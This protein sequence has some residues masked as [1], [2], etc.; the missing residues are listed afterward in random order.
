MPV[1]LVVGCFAPGDPGAVGSLAALQGALPGWDVLVAARADGSPPAGRA[2]RGLRR[3]DALVVTGPVFGPGVRPARRRAALARLGLAAAFEVR[4]RPRAMIGVSVP[5]LDHPASR[6]FARALVGRAGLLIL[7]DAHSAR[8][9]AEAGAP[10]P[11]R[12]GADPAWVALGQPM[13][14]AAASPARI[15]AVL[16]GAAGRLAHPLEPALATLAGEGMSLRL[17]PWGRP[18]RRRAD[19]LARRLRRAGPV[20]I[21][22]PPADLRAAR[23]VLAGSRGVL[24]PGYHAAL[25]A[26][27][28]GVSFAA[29][30]DEPGLPALARRLG[31]RAAASNADA[32]ELAAAMRAA[33]ARPAAG[34]D[35]IEAEMA[36]AREGLRLVRLLLSQG[37]S[38]D[39]RE[40][41][42]LRLEPAP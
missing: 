11:F 32:A 12:V 2:V 26:A 42:G 20:E 16:A 1:A 35:V 34:G 31:Q 9:L 25:A 17:V 10:A 14:A 37:R 6:A 13:P 5:A 28:A 30:G 19:V 39:P 38:E 15:T 7:R 40:L 8:R 21:T 23:D 29:L 36:S 27:A 3:A 4:A 41:E 33:L 24:A 18:F 22:D